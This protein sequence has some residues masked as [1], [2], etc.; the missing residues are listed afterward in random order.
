MAM[1]V[2]AVHAANM[3]KEL[4][5]LNAVVTGASR[6]IGRDTAL[7]L[8]RAGANVAINAA[9]SLEEAGEVAGAVRA[10]G[11]DSFPVRCDV[12]DPDAVTA[13]FDAVTG[14]WGAIDIVVNNAGIVDNAPA[15]AMTAAQWRRMI[16]VNLGGVFFC[17]QAAGRAMIISGRGGSIV[18][19]TSIC[20]HI[21]V[22][23]QKQCHYNAAK[24]GV[25][26]LTK[27]LAAEWAPHNIRVNAISPGYINTAL[28]AQMHDLHPAWEGR[29]PMARLGQPHEI[30][31]VVAFL[32]G[33]RASF[34]TGSDWIVDGGYECW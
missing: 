13:M 19:V 24:G 2:M 6:G 11:V 21:V 29:T 8:A 20:A 31:D 4:R 17:A 26:M 33:P 9:T 22:A 27:S 5:G 23:P 15:E 18:N 10:L 30:A 12:A 34:V 32:A 14:R 28:V 16:D 7:A 1:G 25:V 3:G